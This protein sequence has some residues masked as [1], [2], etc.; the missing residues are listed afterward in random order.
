MTEPQSSTP[1]SRSKKFVKDLGLYAIGNLGSKLIT[2]L[3]VPFYTH[4]I[5]NTADYGYYELAMTISFCFVPILCFQMTDGGFRFLIETKDI[6]RHRA[7]VSFITRT[8]ITNILIITLLAII[9]NI[10]RP[11]KFLPYILAY[12]ISQTIYEVSVQV[13][14]GLGETKTF[15]AAG[16][17]NAFF[18]ALLSIILLAGVG[19]GIDGIFIA[20]IAAKVITLFFIDLRIKLFKIYIR[21]R[22]I[23]KSVS[24]EL[25]KYS[26]PL[27]P[28]A[29]CW[30]F[31][32][33]NNQFFIERYLGLTENG[34]YGLVCRFTG[35]LYVL[36][37]IF[38]QTWQ[39]NAIEQYNSPDRNNFFSSVFNNY[40]YLLCL[41]V[42][43]FPFALRLNYSWLVG[44][45]YQTSNQYLFLN[46]IYV[47]IF[48][49]A[50]FFEIGY[51]CAKRTARILPSLFMAIAISILSNILLTRNFGINGAIL[52]SIL[53]Y[54]ALLIY[55]AAD[56]RKFIRIRFAAKNIWPLM[57]MIFAGIGYHLFDGIIFDSVVSISL[58]A[59]FII[60]APTQIKS[61]VIKR[62]IARHFRKESQ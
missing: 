25:L 5:T 55:R 51:Q 53:T 22:F 54:S 6:D 10:F 20:A 1:P 38:Y 2:F 56:T 16:I 19:M 28:V 30:W 27:I 14:R 33:A 29:L 60:A 32:T 7:I 18:T 34:Y 23:V 44:A 49:L 40:L 61:A 45:E 3:L 39:Q 46:S 48:A 8:L 43:V 41:L 17:M 13:T 37:N 11:V 57:I 47:M 50:A 42:S 15:V 58:L 24:K 9:F 26:L 35:I 21:N 31:I 36:S 52:S 12:G 62:F 4:Y 59:L